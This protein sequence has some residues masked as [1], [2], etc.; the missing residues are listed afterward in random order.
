M[1]AEEAL[2]NT[3]QEWH[4]LANAGSNAIQTGNWKLLGECQ[5]RVAQF[6][7]MIRRLAG[8]AREEWRKSGQDF[9]AKEKQLHAII[10]G[11]MDITRE[12]QA[13]IRQRRDAT[14]IKL[15]EC[16]ATGRNLQRIKTYARTQQANWVSFS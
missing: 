2:L 7:P 11:L 16:T 13:L 8:E 14:R 5:S 12:N 9:K 1:S 6:Q 4:R 15:E 10:S 3:Y